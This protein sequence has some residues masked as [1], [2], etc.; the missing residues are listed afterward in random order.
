V[1]N[2]FPWILHK[3]ADLLWDV[4]ES[5]LS[6]VTGECIFLKIIIIF[7]STPASSAYGID[8]ANIP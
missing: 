1:F 8:L 4:S 6:Q 3:L 5:A 2:S 7:L